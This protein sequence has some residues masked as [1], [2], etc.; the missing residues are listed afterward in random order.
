MTLGSENGPSR[1]SVVPPATYVVI[2]RPPLVDHSQGEGADQQASRGV[3]DHGKFR[4]HV[5]L[6]KKITTQ[7]GL[8]GH[9]ETCV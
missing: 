6:A 7:L 4:F 2:R 9:I 5:R 8:I 3:G 1:V